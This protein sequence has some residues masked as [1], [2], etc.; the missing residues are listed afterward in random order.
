MVL[1]LVRQG[2]SGRD[3]P[4]QPGRREVAHPDVAG[5]AAGAG[6]VQGLE[7]LLERHL[8]VGPVQ[9]QQVDGVDAQGGEALLRAPEQVRAPEV[10]RPHLRGEE[11]VVAR[12]AGAA[13][14]LAHL[15]LVEVA[16]GRVEVPIA[17]RE[18]MVDRAHARVAAEL[19]RAQ[20]ERGNAGIVQ[21]T[22]DHEATLLRSRASLA[23]SRDR[24]VPIRRGPWAPGVL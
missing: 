24:C 18:S 4:A 16:L 2:G 5:Q 20:P 15:R 7:R 10:A 17:E 21:V 22:V 13:Q 14:P 12:Q 8:P 3:R 9:Q 1:H 19:P 11:D 6:L 23:A